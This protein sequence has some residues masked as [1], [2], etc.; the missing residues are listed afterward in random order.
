MCDDGHHISFS[1]ILLR[2]RLFS[3]LARAADETRILVED[4][5]YRSAKVIEQK[6]KTLVCVWTQKK[7]PPTQ[8]PPSPI[9]KTVQKTRRNT[10]PWVSWKRYSVKVQQEQSAG[11][12]LRRSGCFRG[13]IMATSIGWMSQ[14]R[15]HAFMLTLRRGN[16]GVGW[17]G[18]RESFCA[19][20]AGSNVVRRCTPRFQIDLIFCVLSR[21]LSCVRFAILELYIDVYFYLL[22][23]PFSSAVYSQCQRW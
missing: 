21:Q 12:R 9:V 20:R 4:L 18:E 6:F 7:R 22:C 10:I 14:I 19:G 5:S 23:Y 13:R 15:P 11:M 3:F 16:W 2:P 8:H 17:R 1:L